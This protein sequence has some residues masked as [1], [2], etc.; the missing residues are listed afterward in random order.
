MQDVWTLVVGIVSILFGILVI[1]RP[2]VLT[3]VVG[4]YLILVG[5]LA[6]LRFLL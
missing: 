2:K 3:Y 5:I 4:V 1:V 6:I